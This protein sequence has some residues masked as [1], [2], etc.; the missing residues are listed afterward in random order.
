MS[1]FEY[2]HTSEAE[3]GTT[4]ALAP[5]MTAG[6]S[7]DEIAFHVARGERLRAAAIQRW[8]RSWVQTVASLWHRPGRLIPKTAGEI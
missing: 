2:G 4:D 6:L 1:G 8:G 5:G 7:R 3:T